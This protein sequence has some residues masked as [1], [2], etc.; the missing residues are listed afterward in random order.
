MKR[1]RDP[2]DKQLIGLLITISIM[3]KRL[4]QELMSKRKEAKHGANAN[5]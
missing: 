1:A 5:L 4:A 2:D 3:S